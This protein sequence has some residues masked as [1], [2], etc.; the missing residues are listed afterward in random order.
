MVSAP[1]CF[2]RGPPARDVLPASPGGEDERGQIKPRSAP[3]QGS[4][5]IGRAVLSN[6]P[7]VVNAMLTSI[8]IRR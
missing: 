7:T 1:S 4:R 2:V 6:V 5:Q 8:S 3:P